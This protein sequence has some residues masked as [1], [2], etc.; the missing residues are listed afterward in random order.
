M[1]ISHTFYGQLEHILSI[2]L[3]DNLLQE[4][5]TIPKTLVL[6]VIR[7]CMIEESNEDLDIHYYSHLGPLEIVDI[8]TVM[9]VVGRIF[10]RNRW[11]II[12]KSG[13]LSRA[14]FVDEQP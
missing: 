2:K 12:D 9:C 3:T 8:S 1:F 4:D 5:D 10:D 6:G 13:A 14:I 11:A 7:Q